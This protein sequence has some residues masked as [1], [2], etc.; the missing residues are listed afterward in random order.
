[1]GFRPLGPR[2]LV[3]FDPAEDGEQVRESGVIVPAGSVE[4]VGQWGTVLAVGTCF[5]AV[6]HS[7]EV[8]RRYP[9]C[10]DGVVIPLSEAGVR[11]GDRVL[12]IRYLKETHTGQ[13]LR[14]Q[15]CIGPDEFVIE[16]GDVLA[17]A[18]AAA[19][20]SQAQL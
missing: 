18:D 3:R 17:V 14:R 1:M 6:D 5:H 8:S 4:H 15:H 9:I 11:V 19:E 10:R 20:D 12:Y 7:G 16:L 2:F 13:A